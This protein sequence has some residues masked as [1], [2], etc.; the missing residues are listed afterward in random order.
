MRLWNHLHLQIH[1]IP[2]IHLFIPI[3]KLVLCSVSPVASCPQH[4]HN[5]DDRHS[6]QQQSILCEIAL[7]YYF[8]SHK[9]ANS[10]LLSWSTVCNWNYACVMPMNKWIRQTTSVTWSGVEW[11]RSVQDALKDSTEP[12]HHGNYSHLTVTCPYS[13]SGRAHKHPE[14]ATRHT[15]RQTALSKLTILS[16]PFC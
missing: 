9:K 11:C 14:H 6:V 10:Q 2:L 5:N 1:H 15:N 4:N 8:L 12:H 13:L 7:I 16:E 3:I